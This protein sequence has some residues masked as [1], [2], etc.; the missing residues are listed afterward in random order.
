M[1]TQCKRSPILRQQFITTAWPGLA[2]ICLL[3]LSSPAKSSLRSGPPANVSLTPKSITSPA[4]TPEVFE[5][6]YSDP[7]GASNLAEV[8]LRVGNANAKSFYVKYSA[9]WNQLY[10]LND[11]GTAYLGGFAPGSP[12]TITNGQ[13]VLD[14]A[15]TTISPQGNTL[16]VR[17]RLIPSGVFVGSHSLYMFARNRQ[18]YESAFQSMGTWKVISQTLCLHFDGE[19]AYVQVPDSNDFSPASHP[20]TIAAWIRPDSTSFPYCQD[21]P[22][23]CVQW[24]GKGDPGYREWAF[25][26]Y[27]IPNAQNRGNRT[28]IYVFNPQGGEGDGSYFQDTMSAGEKIFITAVVTPDF[29]RIYKN[30]VLRAS[31]WH[32]SK[33]TPPGF[34]PPYVIVT[35][36]HGPSDLRVG[37]EDFESYWFGSISRFRIWTREL[38]ASEISQLYQADVAPRTGLALEYLFDSDT[39]S[40]AVDTSG[41]GH[42]GVIG[43][44]AVFQS[45]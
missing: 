30:G 14:C 4:G 16:T 20:I 19:T 28:S 18:G 29:T 11:A 42:N 21:A 3:F 33:P 27:S 37:T 22:D 7:S 36:V 25:R 32:S 38:S 2:M 12:H 6:V 23:S 13:G 17:W 39:G 31:N 5:A 44:G 43:G 45:W 34:N 8:S 1:N 40:V 35:P 24:A 9:V 15:R 41:K 26:T 10:M